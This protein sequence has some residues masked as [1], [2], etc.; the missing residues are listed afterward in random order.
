MFRQNLLGMWCS[1]S[2]LPPRGTKNWRHFP[3]CFLV[4]FWLCKQSQKEAK[5]RNWCSLKR[6]QSLLNFSNIWLSFSKNFQ[7]IIWGLNSKSNNWEIWF[8]IYLKITSLQFTTFPKITVVVKDKLFSKNGSLH[9]CNNT[10]Q[11]CYPWIRWFGKYYGKTRNSYGTFLCHISWWQ[12]WSTFY[13]LLSKTYFW[14]PKVHFVRGQNN[15]WILRWLCC[16][17]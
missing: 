3:W 6:I 11:A 2:A 8:R 14:L 15:A 9:S 1:E 5:P 10:S 17:I 13:P 7:C 16:T 4:V 12:V